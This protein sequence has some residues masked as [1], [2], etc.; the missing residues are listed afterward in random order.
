MAR[1]SGAIDSRRV[2][3]NKVM[4]LEDVRRWHANRFD[5]RK[6]PHAMRAAAM[7]EGSDLSCLIPRYREVLERRAGMNGHEPQS[8]REI[9]AALGCSHERVR[10][11]ESLAIFRLRRVAEEGGALG[12]EG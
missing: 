1:E 9:A 11:L 12:A 2:G 6:R 7:I 5:R 4:L 10:Q 3:K 8:L